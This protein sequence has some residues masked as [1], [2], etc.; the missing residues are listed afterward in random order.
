MKLALTRLGLVAL[1][2][3]G[4][5]G[6][7][8]GGGGTAATTPPPGGGTPPPTGVGPVT[9]TAAALAVAATANGEACSLCH[10]NS[11]YRGGADHQADYDQL[12]QNG[13][14]K[15]TGMTIA[16]DGVSKTT[17]SFNLMNGATPVDCKKTGTAGDGFVIGA[18]YDPYD[19]ATRMFTATGFPMSLIPSSTGTAANDIISNPA[20][21]D[22]TFIRTA[23]SAAEIAQV[24]A[25]GV[26]GNSVDGVISVYGADGVVEIPA[27]PHDHME[28]AKYP[29]GGILRLGPAMGVADA[30]Y[31]S[32]A[33]VTGCENCHTQPFNKHAY[34]PGTVDD[35]TV[36]SSSATQ[37]FYIC[38]TCHT[39]KRD[40]GDEFW[41]V[42]REAKDAVPTDPDYQFLRNLAVAMDAGDTLDS[43]QQAYV[44]A[45]A[46]KT[47]L[48]N[49]VHM[50]HAMEFAYPQ[51][52]RNC[53]TCHAGKMGTGVGEIFNND[54][55]KAETCISCHAFRGISAKM[56]AADY[57]HAGIADTPA[58]MAATNCTNCHDGSI[59]TAPT[60]TQ[61]HTGGYDPLI[62][63]ADGTRYSTNLTVSID[64]AS[65]DSATS[66][67]TVNFTASGSV[68]SI[69]ATSIVPTVMVGLYG[70]DTKDFI[71]AAHGRDS[72]GNRLLE[73]KLGDTNP[74]FTGTV[75]SPGS[76]T[77]TADLSAWAS[78]LTDGTV[79]RAEI[80]VLPEV[81]DAAGRTLGLNAPSK[82][83]AF[84]TNGFVNFYTDEVVVMK[85][86]RTLAASGYIGN[87]GCNTCHD[88]L[89]T[90]FHSGIRGGNIR[91]CR[92]CH[93]KSSGGS[94]LEIQS[95]SI[96]SYVH[97]IHSFQDFDTGD[98]NFADGFE[99]MEYRHHTESFFPRFGQGDGATDCESCHV[100]GAY[101]PSNQS[102]S[103]P[104]IWSGTDTV[105]DPARTLPTEPSVVSG[106]AATACGGCHRAHKIVENDGGGL[107]TLYAHWSQFGYVKTTIDTLWD[108][109]VQKFH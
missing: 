30:P 16:T 58:T 51:R 100:V 28:K 77:V 96:D 84:G 98:I 64:S 67:L 95:R 21:G 1:V 23:T 39:D 42:L 103:L 7:G 82:T 6:C 45:R 108:A 85:T 9:P 18:R 26:A 76:W 78:M 87:K 12:Y 13:K 109:L 59:P 5:A 97:A 81:K 83:F 49:D 50:S 88:Q 75:N 57:N 27:A 47:R 29:F 65:F 60:F 72:D 4:L 86:G 8:G 22:C 2:V 93:V 99:A 25:M 34:I 91:V 14:I 101:E 19:A 66:M 10:N 56:K 31:V 106:P 32:A 55:F 79:K 61:V 40:G 33:N 48:M 107:T 102:K 105:N 20:T 3:A 11:A 68:G 52:M 54:N 37:L 89:A 35:N 15:V 90:T 74:R 80:A 104:A 43:T 71:V 73:Y 24:V 63:A 62:Y 46:Y 17:L 94:H 70:Y 38:K 92:L 53:V 36:G 44:D 41:Q 69:A